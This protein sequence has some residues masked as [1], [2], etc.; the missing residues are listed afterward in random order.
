MSVFARLGIAML[1]A[2]AGGLLFVVF[3]PPRDVV[4]DTYAT[5]LIAKNENLFSRG[6]LPEILPPSSRDIEVN[7]NLDLNISWGKFNFSPTEY[8]YFESRSAPYTD[9]F[10]KFL[11]P[12]AVRKFNA[13][14]HVI[15]TFKEEGFYW[16]FQCKP[17]EGVCDYS[18]F[19]SRG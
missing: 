13:A 4:L 17:Q 8:L 19:F 12:D 18:M 16:V 10:A 7:N 14:G 15:R 5:L 3:V 9:E 6:W 11:T 2:L 1:I